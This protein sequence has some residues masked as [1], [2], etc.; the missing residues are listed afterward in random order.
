MLIHYPSKYTR[1]QK[2]C[3]CFNRESKSK[4]HGSCK[5]SVL[6]CKVEAQYDIKCQNAIIKLKLV[7]LCD[8]EIGQKHKRNKLWF[9]RCLFEIVGAYFMNKMQ[10]CWKH[11]HME[12]LKIFF[13]VFGSLE[14]LVNGDVV[15]EV[16]G[17][18]IA[19]ALETVKF[20][21]ACLTI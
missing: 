15:P 7:I 20:V 9:P 13:S 1:N 16:S 12:A 10:N 5:R 19:G 18:I 17:W 6:T 14:Q 8:F 21:V 11:D 3:P 4:H 2:H